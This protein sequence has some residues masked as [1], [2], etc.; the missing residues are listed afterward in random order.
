[1]IE[2]KCPE[3]RPP[4]DGEVLGHYYKVP[5]NSA[6]LSKPRQFKIS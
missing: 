2:S 3:I 5:D 4:K 6:Y 1:M